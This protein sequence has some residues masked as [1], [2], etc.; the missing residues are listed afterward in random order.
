MQPDLQAH[1]VMTTPPRIAGK[2]AAPK[3]W[4]VLARSAEEAE[5]IVRE[6]VGA[7]CVVQVTD[8]FLGQDEAA[9]IGL[10]PGH[11]TAL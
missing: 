6:R 9:A 7:D 1:V 2:E 3:R 11:A 5:G 8:D 10:H 4:A